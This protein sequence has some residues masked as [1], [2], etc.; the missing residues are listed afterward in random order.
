M[1]LSGYLDFEVESWV[2][3]GFEF[4][5]L[6]VRGPTVILGASRLVTKAPSLS[7]GPNMCSFSGMP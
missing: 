1:E 5:Q 7:R 4:I 2:W 6:P 3:L